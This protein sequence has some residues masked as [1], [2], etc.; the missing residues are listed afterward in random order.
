MHDAIQWGVVDPLISPLESGGSRSENPYNSTFN[1][2]SWSGGSGNPGYLSGQS[3]VNNLITNLTDADTMNFYF[4]GHGSTSTLGDDNRQQVAI[5]V[6]QVSYALGNR[7]N[8]TNGAWAQ[9]PYRFVFLNACDTADDHDW[10]HAFGIFDV[11]R[12]EQLADRPL[13]AQAFLGWIGE[14]RAPDSD[15]EWNDMAKTFTVFFEAWQGGYNLE[16]C[17][18]IASSTNPYGDGSVILNFPFGKK[19]FQLFGRTAGNMANN[20]DLKI[21]GYPWITRT[22]YQ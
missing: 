3:D 6:T 13:G 12:P 19:Y 15:D 20:F 8:A 1:D 4:D 5:F 18:Q 11:I 21:Y 10:A 17:I 2:Y 14:P 9:H 16:E 22:G 7:F